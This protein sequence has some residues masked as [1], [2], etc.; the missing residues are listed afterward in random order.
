MNAKYIY[1]NFANFDPRLL[2][3]L[4]AERTV[5]CKRVYL[6]RQRFARAIIDAETLQ[7]LFVNILRISGISRHTSRI[8][9]S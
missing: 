4:N 5:C 3:T 6:T 8:L 1:R 2:S 7:S 9:F